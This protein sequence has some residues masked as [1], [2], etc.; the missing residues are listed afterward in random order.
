M[1][2]YVY[3]YN[4]GVI[5]LAEPEDQLYVSVRLVPQTTVLPKAAVL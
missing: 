5:V 3:Y 2:T 4:W 1:S